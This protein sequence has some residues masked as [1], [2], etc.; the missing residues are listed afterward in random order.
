LFD[1]VCNLC[2]GAVNFLLDWDKSGQYR[3]AALQ[4]PAG[5]SLLQRSGRAPNDI[6]SIVLVE[7]DASYIK[8]EAILRIARRLNIPFYMLA[9]L[10]LPVPLFVRDPVYDLVA[11]NRYNLLGKRNVCRLG[12]ERFTERFLEA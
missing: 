6:S 8:S 5:Q 11:N 3:L 12:D 7:Q 2:N 4:S 1:G 10:G 9:S